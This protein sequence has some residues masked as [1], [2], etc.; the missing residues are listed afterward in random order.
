MRRL[1][2]VALIALLLSGSGQGGESARNAL[3][4]SEFDALEPSCGHPA[5]DALTGLSDGLGGVESTPDGSLARF[6]V[7]GIVGGSFAT[8]VQP[9]LPDSNAI[10][11]QTLFTAGGAA[12][13]AFERPYGAWRTEFEA[14]GRER[15]QFTES[16]PL[17]GSTTFRA[18]DGWSTM[19]NVWRDVRL[20]DRAGIYL[21]AGIGAGGYRAVFGG[22]VLGTSVGGSTGIT[23]FA[24][25]AGGGAT[26]S[27]SDRVEIDL[28]YRFFSLEAGS[29]DIFLSTA[30]GTI[31]DSVRT[32]F[33]ASELL[34]SLRI[35]EPFR[36]WR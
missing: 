4:L 6:Y 35:Y 16:D 28:G 34:V 10:L 19:A 36:R 12:G 2:A 18:E 22:D 7:A 11:N 13:W 27:F 23:S 17:A 15:M 29:A 30:G 32:Q 14:R 24:W 3:D 25:Q 5:E 21:G 31:A 26:Y 8:L 1:A 20:F 9:D 33:S